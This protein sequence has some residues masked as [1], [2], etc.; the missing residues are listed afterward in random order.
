MKNI[1]I[2]SISVFLSLLLLN[3]LLRSIDEYFFK[4][5]YIAI[6]LSLF[7]II[8]NKIILRIYSSYDDR[9]RVYEIFVML[10]LIINLTVGFWLITR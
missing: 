10:L 9:V 5:N 3:G 2:S 7:F 8:S 6:F 4:S 1:P